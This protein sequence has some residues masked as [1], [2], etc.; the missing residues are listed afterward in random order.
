M[1]EGFEITLMGFTRPAAVFVAI[2]YV[3]FVVGGVYPSAVVTFAFVKLI[4]P[5]LQVMLSP[6]FTPPS[7]ELEALGNE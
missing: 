7:V 6:I 5:K 3:E 2:V 4:V 1:I